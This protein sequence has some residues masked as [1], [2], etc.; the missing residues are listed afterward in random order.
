MVTALAV[1]DEVASWARIVASVGD[2]TPALVVVAGDLPFDYPA[3]ISGRLDLPGVLV[4]G[5]HDPDST[6]FTQRRGTHARPR[7]CGDADDG[8]HHGFECLHDVVEACNR[9]CCCGSRYRP[10]SA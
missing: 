2:A 8:P 4:A 5:N 6:G 3:E 7:H 10:G 9:A 1:S